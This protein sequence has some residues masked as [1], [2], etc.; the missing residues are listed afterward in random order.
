MSRLIIRYSNNVIKEAD[1]DKP[2]FRIGTADDNDL[3]LE[4][5]GVSP[6]QAEIDTVDGAYSI[7]DVS[8]SKNTMVNGKQI[9]RVNLNY[10]DRINFGPVIGLFYPS[11]ISKMPDKTKMIIF[12]GA[13]AA[14]V[15]F[16]IFFILFTTNRRLQSVFPEQINEVTVTEQTSETYIGREIEAEEGRQPFIGEQK[17]QDRTGP[18]DKR[19]F[20][21][22]GKETAAV[23]LPE[24]DTEDIQ[25]RQS[26][27]IPR[28][29][30]GLFF[31]KQRVYIQEGA[32]AAEPGPRGTETVLQEPGVL[33]EEYPVPGER[34]QI[35]AQET[36]PGTRPEALPYDEYYEES[37]PEEKGILSRIVSPFRKLFSRETQAQTAEEFPSEEEIFDSFLPERQPETEKAEPTF[38]PSPADIARG[39]ESLSVFEKTVTETAESFGFYEKPVYSEDELKQF[40][41]PDIL[42]SVPLSKGEP[43]NTR[44]VWRFSGE[45][46]ESDSV[47]R[48]GTV[49]R[50]DKDRYCDFIFG[51]KNGQLFALSGSSGAQIFSQQHGKPFY[52][53]IIIDLNGDGRDDILL[54]FEDGDIASYTTDLEQ[55]WFYEGLDKITSLPL[56]ID[57]N[58]DGTEDVVFTT[59]GMDIVAIDGRSGFELWR[60]FD[61]ESETL[62]SPVGIKL[63]GDSVHDVVFCTNNGYLYALDGK[64]GWG[65]WTTNIKGAPAGGCVVGDLDGDGA[66]DIVTLSRSGILS[67]FAKDGKPLFTSELKKEY[68]VAPSIGDVDGDGN[69]EIVLLD[70][71]GILKALEGKSRREKW[72]YTA[73]NEVSLGRIALSDVNY[74]GGL[75]A[76]YATL[77]GALRI[78]NGKTGLL[79]GAFHY[80]DYALTT[81]II[82]DMNGDRIHEIGVASY[83]GDVYTVRLAG[84]ERKL[85]AFRKSEWTSTNQNTR[86]TGFSAL[87]FSLLFWN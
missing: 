44:L 63:N 37:F 34:E 1:F 65:L 26:I 77:S 3:V 10:G 56:L 7:V 22:R 78:V 83:S 45:Y 32:E 13:G 60:F 67:G 33:S 47:I 23:K 86:N 42:N 64:T 53:P 46:D 81:P 20:F 15:F 11:K 16:S 24:V 75:D 43:F 29:L 41:T 54:A 48:S 70:R 58:A 40:Q 14:V 74:D 84:E 52:E 31:R 2:K 21:G 79:L 76:V 69:V 38:A 50:I 68:G 61:A 55:I 9:D 18:S 80:G 12:I 36:Q 6:H 30:K 87:S 71:S 73:E 25:N 82:A 85:F 66:K 8:E 49:G 72:S 19:S 28:G 4:D 57:V 35:P 5:E 51:T 39:A 62:H 27:A 17:D 59:L